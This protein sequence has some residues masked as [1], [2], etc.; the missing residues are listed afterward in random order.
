M[1]DF[2]KTTVVL[3]ELFYFIVG[4]QC[5]SLWVGCVRIQHLRYEQ[6]QVQTIR[7]KGKLR[8]LNFINLFC[9]QIKKAIIVV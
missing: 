5:S 6:F 2:R 7:S 4:S 9:S 1:S 3:L 8:A